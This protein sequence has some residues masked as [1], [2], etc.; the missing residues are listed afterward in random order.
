MLKGVS[1][2][3]FATLPPPLREQFGIRLG[4]GKRAAM[5]A[6]FAAT[7]LARPL[8]PPK[9][10][11]IAPYQEWRLRQRGIEPSHRGR[12]GTQASGDQARAVARV[13]EAPVR[14]LHPMDVDG[15]L[16]DIDGVLAVSWEPIAGAIDTLSWIRE[17]AIP[18]RL[19]HEH[20]DAHPG[21]A[22]AAR[23]ATRGST[24]EAGR[25]HHRGRRRPRHTCATHHAG[26][27]RA[28]CCPTGTRAKTSKAS[29]SSSADEPAD[30]VVIGGACDDFTYATLNHVFGLLKDGAALIGMH[31]NLY[32][33]TADGLQLDGGAY[34][35]GARGGGRHEGH[36]L[37][38]ARA[39][40]SSRRRS[41]CSA[42]RPRGP[43]WS[44]TTS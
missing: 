24:V 38:Q 27:T 13:A 16:L 30:V 33:R 1:R 41:R 22:R 11:Y 9:V 35:A 29:R 42:C 44:A 31:R 5:R 34:I 19:D 17:Q 43:R 39:G 37:R 15:L 14:R 40:V 26:R 32:W 6:T 36:D 3:A 21:G 28:S 8:L 4:P 18:F 12:R 10:R 23:S 7:R 20:D 2:L 25:H